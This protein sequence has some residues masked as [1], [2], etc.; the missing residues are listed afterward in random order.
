MWQ[1]LSRYL[2]GTKLVS[3]SRKCGILDV[4][5]LYGPTAAE[6]EKT[7]VRPYHQHLMASCHV[8]D[9]CEQALTLRI[10]TSLS[11]ELY[12]RNDDKCSCPNASLNEQAFFMESEVAVV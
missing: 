11:T 10:S 12:S 7:C 8:L 1:S 2:K 5:Q 4:S 9:L 3:L 6:G